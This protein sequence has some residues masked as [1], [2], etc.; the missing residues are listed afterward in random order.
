MSQSV[1]F[2]FPTKG[3]P[4]CDVTSLSSSN[5]RAGISY[6]ASQFPETI[7]SELTNSSS[8]F[9]TRWIRSPL[10]K[11]QVV[12]FTQIPQKRGHGGTHRGMHGHERQTLAL[13]P[14]SE[15][16]RARLTRR[17]G[18]CEPVHDAPSTPENAPENVLIHTNDGPFVAMDWIG[19]LE[20]NN[21]S[22]LVKKVP[23]VEEDG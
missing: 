16:R 5:L 2:Q 8:Q 18:P 13:S 9:L 21:V 7:G 19:M 4:S 15:R 1:R 14:P 23:R 20:K 17:S 12:S 6:A 10:T 3:M 11:A 22:E